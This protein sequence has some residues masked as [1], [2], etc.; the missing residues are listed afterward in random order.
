MSFWKGFAQ[1][2]RDV[3][4]KRTKEKLIKEERAYQ[5]GVR[6][7]DRA[8]QR[9]MFL[10]RLNA[11]RA[12]AEA[13]AAR[14]REFFDYKTQ[15][16]RLDTLLSKGISGT[17]ASG[18]SRGGG[19]TGSGDSKGLLLSMAETWDVDSDTLAQFAG[20][21]DALKALDKALQDRAELHR[22]AGTLFTAEEQNDLVLGAISTI[23]N[24]DEVTEEELQKAFDMYQPYLGDLAL[25][26]EIPGTGVT[27]EDFFRKE[28]AKGTVTPVINQNIAN[29]MKPEDVSRAVK[30]TQDLA[31]AQLN[32]T[33][34]L[35]AE[36]LNEL[37]DKEQTQVLSDQE[38]QEQAR[39]TMQNSQL[40]KI[41]SEVKG[42][43]LGSLAGTPY[44]G[45]ILDTM[46]RRYVNFD[47]QRIDPNLPQLIYTDAE[48]AARDWPT[49]PDGATVIVD[50]E[51]YV[52][53]HNSQT[54]SMPT[55]PEVNPMSDIQIERPS[56]PPVGQPSSMVPSEEPAEPF[57][58][59]DRDMQLFDPEA[60]DELFSFEEFQ[61]MSDEELERFGI[62][63][64][65]TLQ[66]NREAYY[67]VRNF[68]KNSSLIGIG[69]R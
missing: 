8:F 69:K 1:A 36:R 40:G 44:I 46:K 67:K 31:S 57:S 60:P 24:V 13:A 32:R 42:G 54:T 5:E 56:I 53:D 68:L 20:S 33:I 18:T 47:P 41:L 58:R 3:D 39:L 66:R 63:K 34:R 30:E 9:Q 55:E 21:A 62:P 50:G 22:E 4:E 6:K 7:E 16:G 28:L 29:P 11:Q 27:V 37:G 48:E 65:V 15:Q 10:E 51:V 38:L 12:D 52:V 26:D 17:S 49:L 25:E 19:S 61:N 23:R 14:D 45:P 35:N 43:E 64:N 2:F 59:Q